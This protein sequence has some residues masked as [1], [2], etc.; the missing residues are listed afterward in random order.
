M[1]TAN[2]VRPVPPTTTKK[3]DPAANLTFDLHL[4]AEEEE[5]RSHVV[6][7]Y[8]RAQQDGQTAAQQGRG[9]IFYETDEMDEF[10]DSDPDDDLDF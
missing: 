10:E 3:T 8:T 2:H 1:T 5:A 6:L 4:S 7:P 9:E